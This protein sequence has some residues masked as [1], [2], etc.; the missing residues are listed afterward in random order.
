MSH[1]TI[2]FALITLF[3]NLLCQDAID[4]EYY[5]GLLGPSKVPL[6]FLLR[7]LYDLHLQLSIDTYKCRSTLKVS[8][9]SY[10]CR[11]YNCRSKKKRGTFD[12]PNKPPYNTD[13]CADRYIPALRLHFLKKIQDWILK[14]EGFRNRIFRFFTRR[15]NSRSRGSWRVKE[16]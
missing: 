5:G 13:H 2:I 1:S 3:F 16:T 10:K 15:I 7:Q 14:S 4:I 8:I 9:D 6:F 12:G 11:S